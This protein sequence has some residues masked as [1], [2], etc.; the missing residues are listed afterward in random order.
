M[1]PTLLPRRSR[2]S[3]SAELG[4]AR[5][6]GGAGVSLPPSPPTARA[7]GCPLV[8]EGRMSSPS[9][10]SPLCDQPFGLCLRA[11]SLLVS[12]HEMQTGSLG[13]LSSLPVVRQ[14][15]PWTLQGPVQM[16]PCALSL[17]HSGHLD[18]GGDQCGSKQGGHS[19]W[20]QARLP[21]CL[22]A[23]RCPSRAGREQM[24]ACLSSTCVCM[25]V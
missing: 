15:G 17:G 5:A 18:G 20:P 1:T 3:G 23:V 13:S 14:D 7:Q 25:R 19:R 9:N 12:S 24:G 2:G 4:G 16:G 6:P 21:A 11:K 8:M 10:S 22:G